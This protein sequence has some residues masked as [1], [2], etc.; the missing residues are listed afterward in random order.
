MLKTEIVRMTYHIHNTLLNIRKRVQ[1]LTESRIIVINIFISDMLMTNGHNNFI[2]L[3]KP[4][5][6]AVEIWHLFS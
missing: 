4:T 1:K 5:H 6:A 2:Y 3:D